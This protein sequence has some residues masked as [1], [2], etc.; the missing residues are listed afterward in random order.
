MGDVPKKQEGSQHG[1]SKDESVKSA[2]N[3]AESSTAASFSSNAEQDIASND[4]ESAVDDGMCVASGVFR[5]LF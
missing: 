4:Q 2:I 1:S 3:A 5:L